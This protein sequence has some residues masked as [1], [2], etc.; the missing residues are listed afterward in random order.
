MQSEKLIAGPFNHLRHCRY[1]WMLFNINDQFVGRSL[2]L[3]GEYSEGEMEVFRQFVQPGHVVLD[4]G[5]NIGA[6]TLYF[7]NTVGRRGTV[8]AFEPQRVVFQTL[9]ANM[10]LN[11]ISH[12]YCNNV[13]VGA[14]SGTV[15]VPPLDAYS[16]Q[17][18]GSLSLIDSKEGVRVQKITLDS[19][20][21]SRCNFVKIDVEGMELHVLRGAQQTIERHK[22]VL[23]VEN[24]R[25]DQSAELTRFIDSLGYDMYRHC[26]VYYNP[27]NWYQNSENV[28]GNIASLNLLCIPQA[29]KYTLEG[30]SRVMPGEDSPAK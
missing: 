20:N 30:L 7:A 19:L 16:S 23:Y 10:A 29:L 14:E 13:A 17:N 1:G 9:C 26:P 15:L 24:D 18:F 12:V 2:E 11:S 25:H 5:A 28:F 27:N 3:Y 6:H 8:L 21:L 4:V 22:P